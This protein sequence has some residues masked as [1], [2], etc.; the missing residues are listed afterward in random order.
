M[1]KGQSMFCLYTVMYTTDIYYS[2]MNK[3]FVKLTTLFLFFSFFNKR[4]KYMHHIKK[5]TDLRCMIVTKATPHEMVT[6]W[7]TGDW[8]PLK[9]KH[10]NIYAHNTLRK[11]RRKIITETA[12]S[13]AWQN[14]K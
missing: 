13:N 7:S 12:R 4:E 5:N 14:R 9:H 2:S 1:G 8:G 3:K 11:T 6:H 10:E